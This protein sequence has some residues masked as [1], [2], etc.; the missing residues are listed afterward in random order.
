MGVGKLTKDADIDKHR[1]YNYGIWF[2][3]KGFFSHPFGGTGRNVIIFGVYMSSSTK[4]D[5]RK[6][7]VLIL[8]E[9]PPQ[10]VEHTLSEEKMYSINFTEKNKNFVW[11]CIATNK[12]ATY[13]LMVQ[14]FINL[15]KMILKFL[16]IHYV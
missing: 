15:N 12:I 14:K 7:D 1:C 16:Q 13:L 4:I 5:N 9:G 10:G 6:K 3:R 2:D 11:A 8:G